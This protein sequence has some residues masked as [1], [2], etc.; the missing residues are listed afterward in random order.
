[1]LTDIAR[2]IDPLT[3]EIQRLALEIA[4]LRLEAKQEREK[5]TRKKEVNELTEA[6]EDSSVET[7]SEIENR[8]R[9][10]EE[11]FQQ[12]KEQDNERL[13]LHKAARELYHKHSSRPY[14]C[15]GPICQTCYD[16]AR[17]FKTYKDFLEH[18]ECY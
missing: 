17:S 12:Q 9:T 8:R 7:E 18:G 2:H 13:Q 6:N 16:K 4:Q 3:T 5:E 15:R 14:P 1:M 11:Q 10:R